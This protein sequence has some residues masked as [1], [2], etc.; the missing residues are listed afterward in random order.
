[1]RNGSF[2]NRFPDKSI[3]GGSVLPVSVWGM[4]SKGEPVFSGSVPLFRESPGAM[5]WQL[6][7]IRP[8]PYVSSENPRLSNRNSQAASG[9][10]F[11]GIS[12][13]TLAAM[14]DPRQR[15]ST[16]GIIVKVFA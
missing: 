16:L 7:A 4:V 1:M 11:A 6:P 13:V 9:L 15:R 8:F 5:G 3:P 2:T 12:G 10:G 14:C